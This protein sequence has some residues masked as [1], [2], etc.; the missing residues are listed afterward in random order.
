MKTAI[1]R[2]KVKQAEMHAKFNE[3]ARML[4]EAHGYNTPVG[5]DFSKSPHPHE[6]SMFA[7]AVKTYNFWTK[8]EK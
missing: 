1:G 4:Y 7:I 2:F 5:F 3:C 6:Q 8:E